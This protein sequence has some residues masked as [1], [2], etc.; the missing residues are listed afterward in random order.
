M[1]RPSK[2]EIID[3][4]KDRAESVVEKA[5]NLIW[6]RV[7]DFL[8]DLEYRINQFQ[9]RIVWQTA[10][11]IIIGA[12]I[13]LLGLTIYFALTEF[14]GIS[15]TLSTFIISVLLF[16]VGFILIKVKGGRNYNGIRREREFQR[17]PAK[18]YREY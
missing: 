13:I 15:K 18:R 12:S 11:I 8:D 7:D 3:T 9:K 6:N 2:S 1:A 14:A 10:G 17:A 5:G 16:I 4:I